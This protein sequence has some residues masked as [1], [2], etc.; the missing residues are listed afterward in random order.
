MA[1]HITELGVFGKNLYHLADE[2]GFIPDREEDEV[3]DFSFGS[4]STRF[5]SLKEEG[6]EEVEKVRKRIADWN[7]NR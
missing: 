2:L 1:V 6:I 4:R 5:A 3:S 7:N